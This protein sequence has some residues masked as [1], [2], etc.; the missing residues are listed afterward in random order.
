VAGLTALHEAA[1]HNHARLVQL[2][3]EY[4]AACNDRT[5]A[6]LTLLHWAALKGHVEVAH[7]LLAHGADRDARD[8][9]GRTPHD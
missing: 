6:G 3:C 8:A 9:T 7:L 4:G 5:G 2:L 1:M